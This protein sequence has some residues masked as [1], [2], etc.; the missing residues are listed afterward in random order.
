MPWPVPRLP[1]AGLVIVV[2]ACG[3]SPTSPQPGGA[4][5]TPVEAT[6]EWPAASV[7]A[8]GLDPSRL[9]EL[10]GRIR[11]GEYG[12]IDSLLVARHGH[13]VVEEYFNGWSAGRSHT[14][15]SVTKSVV[16]MLAG[17][18][19]GSGRLSLSDSAIRY[20]P[21]YEPIGNRDDRKASMSVGDL[22]A[23]RSGFDWVEDPYP[24]SPLQRLND[25]R[26]DWLRF[27]LDWPMRDPPGTRWEYISGG[28][29]LL[30][31]VVG[32][33]TGMRV[34]RFA[35]AEL[36]GPLGASAVS[37]ASGLPDGLPHAGGGLFLRPR[38][39]AKIG[40]VILDG[41]RW[42]ARPIV[43]ADWVAASTRSV[44][45]GVRVWAGHSYDYGY[46]WWV[47]GDGADLVVAASGARGQWIFAV[48]GRQL[49]AVSTA[50]N[51]TNE[52]AAVGFLYSH[53]LPAVVRE[54]MPRTPNRPE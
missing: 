36:F 41:G 25:C 37:W 43:G 46:G 1:V 49:V 10:A 51:E 39:A 33:A 9:A 54:P 42:Q 4:A 47:S 8:E 28:F 6:A 27:V 11:R 31:G 30:G 50:D 12:R 38:D 3:G 45:P 19:I 44:T 24:G 16:S 48:P 5:L 15:Q 18:A 7:D 17:Q 13:L 34:D 40:Q 32:A 23:M 53:I 21:A 35:D 29:I 22:L 52:T 26:C 14:M 20:F 2:A